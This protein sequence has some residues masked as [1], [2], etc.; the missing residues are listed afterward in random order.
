LA[1]RLRVRSRAR[2]F[3]TAP[4]I[5]LTSLMLVASTVAVWGKRSVFD[6]D[7][8]MNV[9]DP[10]LDE[11]AFYDSLSRNI[12]DQV[13]EALDLETRVRARL[14][15]LDEFL[16]EALV[17][18]VDVPDR[19]RTA[20]SLVDRPSLA[21]L[22]P[23]IVDPLEQRVRDRI[24]GFITSEDF[25]TRVPLLV[26][27]AHEAAVALITGDF[28]EFP[29]VYIADGEVRLNLIPII[30]EALQPV[31]AT[32]SGYLPDITLPAVVS[33]RVTDA[34]QE[35]ADALD[36]RLPD[37]FGQL[38]VVSEDS[39]STLQTGARRINRAT[40]L[41][42]IVTAILLILTVAI[43]KHRRRAIIWMSVGVATALAVSWWVIARIRQA[44]LDQ[45]TAPD[46]RAAIE[47]LLRET[48]SSLRAYVLTVLI[49]AAVAGL[50]A[51]VIA[52]LDDLSSAGRW[53]RRQASEPTPLNARVTAHY[54]ALRMAGFIVAAIALVWAGIAVV[55]FLVIGGLLGLYL[56]ALGAIRRDQPA[57]DPALSET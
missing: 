8:F 22:T 33:D 41:L 6:T 10:A 24:V 23:S 52:H 1:A 13:I 4:L 19:V 5:I 37:D 56:L 9:I 48:R 11:P 47:A 29:N 38:T 45:I 43:A 30:A 17:E 36:V 21:D 34:R 14:T 46:S 20:L 44:V 18:A 12:S 54:D 35:L 55:P 40:W 3:L 50:V 39:L 51:V 32:L 16:A 25:R 15:Q 53:A 49:V 31:V 28:T 27:R 57:A 42:V 2:S 7:R 26:R